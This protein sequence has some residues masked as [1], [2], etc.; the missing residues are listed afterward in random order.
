MEGSNSSDS[1]SR[2]LNVR[3]RLPLHPA[4]ASF[5][6]ESAVVKGTEAVMI[7]TNASEPPTSPPSSQSSYS[8]YYEEPESGDENELQQEAHFY[9]TSLVEPSKVFEE[10]E[11]LEEEQRSQRDAARLMAAFRQDTIDLAEICLNLQPRMWCE[12]RDNLVTRLYTQTARFCLLA[13]FKR[14]RNDPCS[15]NKGLITTL[16]NDLKA[17]DF[18]PPQPRQL[19]R[20][21]RVYP[22]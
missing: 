5:A 9:K 10:K 14:Y 20:E 6:G 22:V 3:V 2:T 13:I 17:D 1:L 21:K 4:P 16:L 12:L 7:E 8:P 11:R 19:P 15:Q 18:P